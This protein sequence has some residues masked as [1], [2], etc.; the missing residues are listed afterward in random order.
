MQRMSKLELS[1]KFLPLKLG[2][3]RKG[4]GKI[5]VVRQGGGQQGSMAYPH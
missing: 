3:H 5:I 1:I 4:K 2:D